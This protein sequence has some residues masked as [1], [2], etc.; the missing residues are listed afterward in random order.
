[1]YGVFGGT[2]RYH[3]LVDPSRPP[4]EEIVTLLMQ[5]R[6]IL[7]NEVR[8]LLGSE[9][10]RDPAPYNAILAAIA[11]GETKFNGIQQLI[12][13]ERGALSKPLRSLLETGLDSTR[14]AF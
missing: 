11:G 6:A 3:A 13:V 9:Q 14:I 4:A 12:G 1:M 7:E 2:P 8:F 5:P 10:I